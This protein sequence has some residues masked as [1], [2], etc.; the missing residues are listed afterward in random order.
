M[1][2]ASMK[3]GEKLNAENAQIWRRGKRDSWRSVQCTGFRHADLA[4]S[5]HSSMTVRMVTPH[6]CND[7]LN[8]QIVTPHFCND[9]LNA[10]MVTPHFC[11]DLLDAQMVTP[12]FCNDLLDAQMV[13][14][15]FWNNHST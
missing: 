5:H 2:T 7:L 3:K 12:H 15:Y 13:T 10:Q 9:L 8:A 6:F 11:N 4:A 1:L 14:P